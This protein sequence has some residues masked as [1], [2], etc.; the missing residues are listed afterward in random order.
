ME[1]MEKVGVSELLKDK[2]EDLKTVAACE[3]YIQLVD[4]AVIAL[5]RRMREVHDKM[6]VLM[7]EERKAEL[8]KRPDNFPPAQSTGLGVKLGK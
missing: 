3:S 5:R 8:A 4:M 6:E 2:R 7:V 1:E